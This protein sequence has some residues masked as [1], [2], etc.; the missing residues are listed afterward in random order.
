MKTIPQPSCRIMPLTPLRICQ[1]GP[2][3]VT[4]QQSY[5]TERSLQHRVEDSADLEED[6]EVFVGWFSFRDAQGYEVGSS[7]ST[8]GFQPHG[9]REPTPAQ[10]HRPRL[11]TFLNIC[12]FPDRSC[13][14]LQKAA[15]FTAEDIPR[16]EGAERVP[17][18]CETEE[19]ETFFLTGD[20]A[21][22]PPA[23]PPRRDGSATHGSTGLL[24]AQSSSRRSPPSRRPS[25][26]SPHCGFYSSQRRL[27]TRATPWI[28]TH[29][30][31]HTSHTSPPPS[32][33]EEGWKPALR[34]A[35]LSPG[36]LRPSSSPLPEQGRRKDTSARGTAPSKRESRVAREPKARVEARE[37]PGRQKPREAKRSGP[38]R[39]SDGVN[40]MQGR[41]RGYPAGA[42]GAAAA[43]FAVGG[44]FA[45]SSGPGQLR[46]VQGGAR[47]AEGAWRGQASNGA[48]SKRVPVVGSKHV[49]PRT[50]PGAVSGPGKESAQAKRLRKQPVAQRGPGAVKNTGLLSFGEEEAA[51]S[52][53]GPKPMLNPILRAG[54]DASRDSRAGSGARQ[55]PG[56]TAPRSN[57]IAT[58]GRAKL[59]A[60][61]PGSA[62]G[63]KAV[64]NTPVPAPSRGRYNQWSVVDDDA[65]TASPETE[66]AD[67]PECRVVVGTHRLKGGR[68]YME[69]RHVVVFNLGP[70]SME[71][72]TSSANINPL[73]GMTQIGGR[74]TGTSG[75]DMATSSVYVGVFDGH[76]GAHCADRA[77]N[78][79]HR[80][81]ALHPG[82]AREP[83]EPD[84]DYLAHNV[85]R[86]A[87][88]G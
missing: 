66:A 33:A 45:P 76:N 38:Q 74:A 41:R 32:A 82:F 77:N 31:Y 67:R 7:G 53:Q 21:P 80:H 85:L 40:T 11:P 28:M 54:S 57:G 43:P 47:D 29:M 16:D 39:A 81:L 73:P 48:P 72:A 19:C 56:Q 69:D 5:A 58:P 44:D 12:G 25:P 63:S 61:L 20:F 9:T 78:E 65:S 88:S 14:F 26:P 27:W 75:G 52:L 35:H 8:R 49:P 64:A 22:P 30:H 86:K 42:T 37:E 83:L 3:T 60:G 6:A 87:D 68:P 59:G 51:P 79:L 50:P 71:P 70:S 62:V 18:E 36:P 34:H 15:D 4:S 17:L 10:L 13:R 24:P 55:G 1:D 84:T 23:S 46:P 2:L